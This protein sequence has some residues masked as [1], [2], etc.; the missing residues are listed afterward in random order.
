MMQRKSSP[1]LELRSTLCSKR[2]IDFNVDLTHKDCFKM[3]FKK[4]TKI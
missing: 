3:I 2:E 4:N 1:I